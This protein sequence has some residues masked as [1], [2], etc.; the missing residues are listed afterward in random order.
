MKVNLKKYYKQ[1]EREAL[2]K[3]VLYASGLGF[4]AVFILGFIFYMTEIKSLW[5]CPL[6]GFIL[7]LSFIPLFYFEKF[8]PTEK[9]ILQRIDLLGLDERMTTMYDYRNDLSEIAAIQ[10]QDAIYSLKEQN[11]AINFKFKNKNEKRFFI[12]SFVSIFMGIIM[13]IIL[14]FMTVGILPS[15][16]KLVYGEEKSVLY[17]VSYMEG[18]GYTISGEAD[19]LVE[20][21]KSTT[22]ITAVPINDSW[23]FLQWS[24][25]TPDNLKNNP[26]RYEENVMEDKILFAIFIEVDSG[27]DK[28]SIYSNHKPEDIPEEQPDS[29]NSDGIS[30]GGNG[31][32]KGNTNFN[33]SI[34]NSDYDNINYREVFESYYDIIS[35]EISNG[36]LTPEQK[37]FYEAYFK[38]LK[39]K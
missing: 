2:I 24:D 17:M 31:S 38:T 7:V 36:N 5:I 19:Q 14:A 10:R 3:S 11:K 30:T 8:K 4:A 12:G 28:D 32:G 25:S 9:E 22:E 37:A 26:T 6:L 35:K 15:G 13:S 33:D 1:L 23:A 21:G 18:D 20:P 27:E 16:S 29:G 39:Q 34:I